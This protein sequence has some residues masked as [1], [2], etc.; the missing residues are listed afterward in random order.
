VQDEG[1]VAEEG[2]VRLGGGGVVV[3]VGLVVG[4]GTLDLAVLAS[5]VT[6]L[7]D[8]RVGSVASNSDASLVGVQVRGSGGAVTSLW[9]G[10]E[11]KV[12][13]YDSRVSLCHYW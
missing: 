13:G 10:L 9:D 11:M 4:T 1:L 7:A 5:Q 8:G 12:V 2:G 3:L 6:N